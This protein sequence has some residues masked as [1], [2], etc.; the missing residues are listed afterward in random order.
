MLFRALSER[1]E[2]LKL[3]KPATHSDVDDPE[4]LLQAVTYKHDLVVHQVAELDVGRL[5]GGQVFGGQLWVQ[6]ARADS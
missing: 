3:L 1:P 4:V 6:V 5:E 2:K